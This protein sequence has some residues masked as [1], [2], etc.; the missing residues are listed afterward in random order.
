M[1]YVFNIWHSNASSLI[2]AMKFSA[3]MILLLVEKRLRFETKTAKLSR[4]APTSDR[5]MLFPYRWLER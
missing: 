2:T 5:I 1:R 4:G 3:R